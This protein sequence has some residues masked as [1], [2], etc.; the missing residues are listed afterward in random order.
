MDKKLDLIYGV[1][2]SFQNGMITEIEC[3]TVINKI[4]TGEI[5]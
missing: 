1:I 2:E 3:R 5:K 4:L